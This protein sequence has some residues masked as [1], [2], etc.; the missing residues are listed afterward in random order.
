MHVAWRLGSGTEQQHSAAATRRR[1][2]DLLGRH[3]GAHTSSPTPNSPNLGGGG[4]K[5]SFLP[6]SPTTYRPTTHPRPRDETE[7]EITDTANRLT[8]QG[9]GNHALANGHRLTQQRLAGTEIANRRPARRAPVER[10][11]L[12]T[13]MD[14]AIARGEDSALSPEPATLVADALRD[15]ACTE[16]A[17]R[18]GPQRSVTARE[19][20]HRLTRSTRSRSAPQRAPAARERSIP[21][22]G[23]HEAAGVERTADVV[24]PVIRFTSS[25]APL[26]EVRRRHHHRAWM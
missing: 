6:S 19:H 9:A 17:S 10:L 1:T 21:E 12:G 13:R 2:R 15:I 14:H 23:E 5:N 11:I 26:F 22:A 24:A 18:R 7:V 8:F 4:F 16:R 25:P 3:S 20:R